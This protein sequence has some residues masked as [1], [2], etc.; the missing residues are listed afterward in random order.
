MKEKPSARLACLLPIALLISACGASKSGDAGSR[1]ATGSPRDGQG[2]VHAT[3]LAK[4]GDARENDAALDL[5]PEG[6]RI[7][8]PNNVADVEPVADVPMAATIDLDALE[9]TIAN[10]APAYPDSPGDA[11][12]SAGSACIPSLCDDGNPCTLDSQTA[13][14]ACVH[15]P[16]K[17]G[18]LCDDGN[19]CTD[20]D[21]CVAGACK[22]VPHTGSPTLLGTARSF[23]GGPSLETVVAFPSQDRAVFL[24]KNV[25]TL[26]QISNDQME[27]LDRIQWGSYAGAYQISP[28]IWVM[29]PSSFIVPLSA[30][31]IAVIG[32]AWSIDLFD[33]SQDKFLSSYR[34]GFGAG[35][36]DMVHAAIA[37]GNNIWTCVGNWIQRYEID[38]QAGLLKQDPGFELAA[39]HNCHGLALSSDGKA[40][41]AA[42]SNG[43]DIVDISS[44]DGKGTVQQTVQAGDFLVDV[45]S[46]GQAIGIYRLDNLTSGGGTVIALG[47]T[48]YAPIA[49]FAGTASDTTIGF[50]MTSGGLLLQQ[51]HQESCRSVNSGLYSMGSPPTLRSDLVAMS[52]C[53]GHFGLPP[54]LLATAGQLL[55][56][57]PAHQVVRIDA[58]SGQMIPV[59]GRA[60]G[61]FARVVA[62]GP[63][64]V[65]VHGPS[66]MQL[67]DISQPSNPVV[68]DGG[69][70]FPMNSDWLRFEISGTGDAVLLT[71]PDSDLTRAGGRASLYW[72]SDKALPTLAGSISNDDAN[73]EWAAAGPHLFSVS[74]VASADFRLRRIPTSG[75]TRAENQSPSAD[76]DQTVTS[77]A[78]TDLDQRLGEA[79]AAD[80]A[81]ADIV[82]AEARRSSSTLA[83]VL[84]WY[85]QDGATYHSVFSRPPDTGWGKD[86][87]V[88]DQRAVL[89]FDDHALLVDKSG[90]T[91]ATYT[92][93]AGNLQRLLSFDE[94]YVYVAGTS[95]DSRLHLTDCVFVFNAA[96]LTLAGQY[97]LPE[98]ALSTAMVGTHRVFGMASTLAV[99][100]PLCGSP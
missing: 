9:A 47:A 62:A 79:V 89:V 40:L 41:L 100:S 39:G 17:D 88:H 66:S 93:P 54:A 83:T 73:A 36:S 71:V 22:G 56:L 16:E 53:S 51:W 37:Q 64:L 77:A 18:V 38:D 30:Q 15:L 20:Q 6:D 78:P 96:D 42:N 32:A 35:G 72:K 48:D 70:L 45:V 8:V 12:D 74:P 10:D 4:T 95:Q 25:L 1:D 11:A 31:R 80:S 50:T 82:I 2:D 28:T 7:D 44:N 90:T 14:C 55:D 68:T 69:L 60:Q 94:S 27:V 91:L 49:T 24:T 52:V 86:L 75:I 87:G 98:P 23:A 46:N 92:H 99:A 76:L 29:R 97:T 57:P 19:A 59:R 5:S 65:E 33:I 3:D 85:V 67:V 13:T 58:S 26:A 34:Y 84:S 43:L 61:S 81:T 63:N 21:Q